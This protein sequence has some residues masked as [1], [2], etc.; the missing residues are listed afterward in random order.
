M[1]ILF[2][3]VI[4]VILTLLYLRTSAWTHQVVMGEQRMPCSWLVSTGGGEVQLFLCFTFSFVYRLN[5]LSSTVDLLRRDNAEDKL[6]HIPLKKKKKT[7]LPIHSSRIRE[8]H[9][10][11]SIN[12]PLFLYSTDIKRAARRGHSFFSP[13]CCLSQALLSWRGGAGC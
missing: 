11:P 10:S 3:I 5:F 7:G 9:G 8:L 13:R 6:T 4:S 1:L 12:T 2:A